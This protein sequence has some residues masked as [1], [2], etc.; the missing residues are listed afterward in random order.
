[1]EENPSLIDLVPEV[2]F[3]AF[4]ESAIEAGVSES[5]DTL[6]EELENGD[7]EAIAS[8]FGAIIETGLLDFD[9]E[10]VLDNGLTASI[11]LND[12]RLDVSFPLG[13]TVLFNTTSSCH[14]LPAMW[15]LAFE[16]QLMVDT[17]LTLMTFPDHTLCHDLMRC[18]S[19]TIKMRVLQCFCNSL[20]HSFF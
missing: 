19:Q 9:T 16:G 12:D 20:R 2:I 5:L 14:S 7:N 6:R 4:A 18:R 8:A 3:N 1:M 11:V 15:N 10:M 13:L 17:I